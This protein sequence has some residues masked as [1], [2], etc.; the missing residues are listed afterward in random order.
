MKSIEIKHGIMKQVF[1]WE[2]LWELG[3]EAKLFK[4]LE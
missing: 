4:K 1:P 3:W 2:E